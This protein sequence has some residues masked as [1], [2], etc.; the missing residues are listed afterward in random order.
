MIREEP[1]ASLWSGIRSFQMLAANT[2]DISTTSNNPIG[3]VGS[4]W[5]GLD[6]ASSQRL[7]SMSPDSIYIKA[8]HRSKR[9]HP[10]HCPWQ[11]KH[12][13]QADS[14]WGD[15]FSH[16]RSSSA[17]K[18]RFLG[19]GLSRVA[20]KGQWIK[21]FMEQ[22]TLYQSSFEQTTIGHMYKDKQTA[23]VRTTLPCSLS[24][25]CERIYCGSSLCH[26]SVSEIFAPTIVYK[27][28]FP[29]APSKTAYVRLHH[30][31]AS[32]RDAN[33]KTYRIPQLERT[34]NTLH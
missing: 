22:S 17:L 34:L 31:S 13:G 24:S 30:A 9:L 15:A 16:R 12:R 1:S 19:T 29:A 20:H 3:C 28:S 4:G 2:S 11:T 7:A 21:R 33:W 23:S 18:Q 25:L 27:S 10:S 8:L 5:Q 26:Q 14:W 32:N 6:N